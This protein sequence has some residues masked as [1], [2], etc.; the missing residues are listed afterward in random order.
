MITNVVLEAL[1]GCSIDVHV[2]P[3]NDTSQ[4]LRITFVQD[5]KANKA[6]RE[7]HQFYIIYF[8]NWICQ[9]L[10]ILSITDS[11]CPDIQVCR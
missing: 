4:I 2:L 11:Q 8:V 5:F 6:R 3:G 1:G 7:Q 10:Q 9:K